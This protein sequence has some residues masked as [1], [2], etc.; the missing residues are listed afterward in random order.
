MTN[1]E[2]EFE[3]GNVDLLLSTLNILKIISE[4]NNF[5]SWLME[6][7]HI[8]ND[9]R[10]YIGYQFFLDAVVCR[11]LEAFE[12]DAAFDLKTDYTFDRAG[13]VGVYLDDVPVTCD[14]AK[15]IKNIWEHYRTIRNC[16]AWNELYDCLSARNEV[17]FKIFDTI[18][19]D[20][21]V[22]E[23]GKSKSHELWE[24]TQ[25][26]TLIFFND[27][28]QGKPYT[29]PGTFL[30]SFITEHIFDK[31]F[32]GYAY[33]LQYLWFKLLGEEEFLKSPACDIHRVLELYDPNSEFDAEQLLFSDGLA[34]LE[35]EAYK[36]WEAL[37]QFFSRINEDV[38]RAKVSSGP[39][40]TLQLSEKF[41]SDLLTPLMNLSEV[42]DPDYIA[43][44]NTFPSLAKKLDSFFF[45]H[46]MDVLDT[47]KVHIFNGASA[48]ISVL[49]GEVEKYRIY[50]NSNPIWVVRIKHPVDK[51]KN[52]ISYGILLQSGGQ[53]TDTS[54]W[55]LF[56]DC[57]TDYSGSGG[58]IHEQIELFINRYEARKSVFVKEISVSSEDFIQYLRQKRIPSL[59]R[60]IK[61]TTLDIIKRSENQVSDQPSYALFE[62]IRSLNESDLEDISKQIEKIV[63]NLQLCIPEKPENMIIK[64]KIDEISVM[65]DISNQLEGIATLLPFI[66][67]VTVNDK[68]ESIESK[69]DELQIK[70][71]PGI[72]GRIIV[73]MGVDYHGTGGKYE[74]EIPTNDV[75][76]PEL[77][78]YMS[79]IRDNSLSIRDLPIRLKNRFLKSIKL[80]SA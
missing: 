3:K 76:Y 18:F 54:G 34:S 78:K 36:R 19:S 58:H 75:D 73:S 5:R 10:L 6:Y 17:V 62:G 80:D 50:K 2:D 40:G 35:H 60:N 57:G 12:L 61:R 51:N 20:Y 16:K 45:W 15:V 59:V 68:L 74:I 71:T 1:E 38:I 63:F 31:V 64:R 11:F 79:K 9:E 42:A 48:F 33:T 13:F 49:I 4:T 28:R 30:D 7:H 32:F 8:T 14:K 55:L 44:Y 69:L 52:D 21:V 56:L 25:F 26:Y 46:E 39:A 47:N 72:H 65:A 53:F 27:T 66:P 41:T 29:Y 43:N 70:M 22:V 37:D 67:Y 77:C 24:K 23:N